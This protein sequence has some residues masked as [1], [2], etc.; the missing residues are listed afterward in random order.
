MCTNYPNLPLIQERFWNRIKDLEIIE[1]I[2]YLEFE[3]EVFPQVWG[4]TALGFGGVGGQ[5]ITNAY[6]TVI[7]ETG[8]GIYG[9]F[10]N[11]RLAYIIENPNHLF[12]EDLNNRNMECCSR[13]SKYRKE[14]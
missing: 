7:Y 3:V 2:N 10:F 6:T 5:V 13:A 8:S 1:E 9:V 14:D 12:F 11:E 4:S